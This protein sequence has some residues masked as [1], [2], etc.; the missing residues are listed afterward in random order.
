MKCCQY[1][2]AFK[3]VLFY[4]VSYCFKRTRF[5]AIF[6]MGVLLHITKTVKNSYMPKGAKYG[7]RK[8]GTGNKISAAL[9]EVLNEYCMNEFQFLNANIER[10]TLHERIILFTKVLPFVLPK[11]GVPEANTGEAS[12][13]P[14]IIFSNKE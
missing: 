8:V 7:G 2:A 10:L 12:K 9:K 11:N 14:I 4:K 13:V 5:A 3:I 1:G 6:I